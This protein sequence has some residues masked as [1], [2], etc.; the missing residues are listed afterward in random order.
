MKRGSRLS[1]YLVAVEMKMYFYMTN[2]GIVVCD[3]N[4]DI[5]FGY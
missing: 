2:L 5:I 3:R 4:K 1:K